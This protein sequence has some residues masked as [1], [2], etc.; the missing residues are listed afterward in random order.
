MSAGRTDNSPFLG[1]SDSGHDQDEML[2]EKKYTDGFTKDTSCMNTKY[3]LDHDATLTCQSS[4]S[5][6]G[7]ITENGSVV[8]DD[9]AK[10]WKQISLKAPPSCVDGRRLTIDE[11]EI[12][13]EFYDSLR[14]FAVRSF[15]LLL[16][17]IVYCLLCVVGVILNVVFLVGWV[18]RG[19]ECC[20][21]RRKSCDTIVCGESM[22]MKDIDWNDTSNGGEDERGKK[23]RGENRGEG[24]IDYIHIDML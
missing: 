4:P 18:G 3:Q 23:N 6:L 8:Q 24:R 9:D 16:Y 14:D 7:S 19:G 5:S 2:V 15:F 13:V 12:N 11:L 22:G 21:C 1:W 17:C 10:F 20:L